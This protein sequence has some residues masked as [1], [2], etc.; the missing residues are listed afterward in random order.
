LPAG[1]RTTLEKL[2]LS[3]LIL[4]LISHHV[5]WKPWGANFSC[6]WSSPGDPLSPMLSILAIDPLQQI[7]RVASKHG[8]LKP[9]RARPASCRVSLSTDDAGIFFN[10]VKE[11]LL[12]VLEILACFR[13]A[14]DLITNV[15]KSEIFPI[16]CRGIYL[17]DILTAFPGKIAAFPGRYL[18]LPFHFRRMRKVEIQPLI[19]KIAA[20]L[21]VWRGKNISWPGRVTL[22][23]SVIT[24]TMI[25][26]MTTIPLLKWARSKIDKIGHGFIWFGDGY[27]HAAGGITGRWCAGRRTLAALGLQIWSGLDGL[28]GCDGRDSNG[29]TPV[30]LGWAQG[31]L[32][33]K[34]TW[35]SLGPLPRLP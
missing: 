32:T 21:P 35:N 16:H 29:T 9:I 4:S 20:K 22:V 33:M 25:Y 14:S 27:E 12:A 7:L 1:L 6:L 24:S 30:D 5:E 26:H 10:P 19:D 28:I 31:S 15:T 8:I 17:T 2:D 18:G 11:E 23:K 13:D 34:R 3:V